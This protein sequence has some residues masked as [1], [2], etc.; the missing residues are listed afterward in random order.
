MGA[1]RLTPLESDSSAPSISP[2]SCSHLTYFN[3][4]TTVSRKTHTILKQV[5]VGT[6]WSMAVPV[7]S[8]LPLALRVI[9][10]PDKQVVIVSS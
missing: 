6:V 8:L 7:P 2:F 9:A 10:I 4:L 5:G 3:Y 1:R